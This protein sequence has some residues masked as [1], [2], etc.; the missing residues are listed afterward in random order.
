MS[1]NLNRFKNSND[2]N[3]QLHYYGHS[4]DVQFVLALQIKQFVLRNCHLIEMDCDPENN[5]LVGFF[6]RPLFTQQA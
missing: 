1:N 2:N 5:L 3:L 4:L 6:N